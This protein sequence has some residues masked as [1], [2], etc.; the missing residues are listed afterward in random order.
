MVGMISRDKRKDSLSCHCIAMT[1]VGGEKTRRIMPELRAG[2]T[3]P[4]LAETGDT[5]STSNSSLLMTSPWM[6][7]GLDDF[8]SSRLWIGSRLKAKA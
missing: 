4:T 5:S 6:S 2:S 7:Q 3:S 1:A 8:R